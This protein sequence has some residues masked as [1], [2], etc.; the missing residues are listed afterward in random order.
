MATGELRPGWEAAVVNITTSIKPLI[1]SGA[2]VGLWFG[3]ELSAAGALPFDAYDKLITKFR[4]ILG[5]RGAAGKLIYYANTAF[6]SVTEPTVGG[7][8]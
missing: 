4:S 7:P 5:D 6:S 2:I 3:D 8:G 1:A